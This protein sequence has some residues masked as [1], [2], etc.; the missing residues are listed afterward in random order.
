VG[1]AGLTRFGGVPWVVGGVPAPGR[2]RVRRFRKLLRERLR[3]AAPGRQ[4][5]LVGGCPASAS[6]LGP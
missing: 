1:G 5:L 2:C 6:G 3:N 4:P